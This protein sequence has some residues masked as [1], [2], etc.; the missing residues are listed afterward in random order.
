MPQTQN[1]GV[2]E[3]PQYTID[4]MLV[5]P[6]KILE[7][8]SQRS[9][10]STRPTPL[11]PPVDM[12]QNAMMQGMDDKQQQELMEAANR[13]EKPKKIEMAPKE[14]LQKM[15]DQK[16]ATSSIDVKKF[17]AKKSRK[18]GKEKPRR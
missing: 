3:L 13:G 16:N 2:I 11:L 9:T 6:E 17:G 4:S 8:S 12:S 14:V 5:Y 18:R 7:W 1:L 10:T 15:E